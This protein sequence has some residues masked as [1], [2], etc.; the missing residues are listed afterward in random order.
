MPRHTCS[1]VFH[2]LQAELWLQWINDDCDNIENE[3]DYQRM[4]TLFEKAVKDY[5]CKYMYQ[6]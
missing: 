1:T 4:I 6:S 5:L 2:F 3:H